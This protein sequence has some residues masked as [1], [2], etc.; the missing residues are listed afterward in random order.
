MSDNFKENWDKHN[1]MSVGP[2][3]D[4]VSS[5]GHIYRLTEAEIEYM[6]NAKRN[7]CQVAIPRTGWSLNGEDLTLLNHG[8]PSSTRAPR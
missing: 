2:K 6:E 7:D 8:I 4:W 5:T 3:F 1:Q